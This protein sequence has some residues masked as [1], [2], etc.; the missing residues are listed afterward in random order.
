MPWHIR[1]GKVV[2]HLSTG[3]ECYLSCVPQAVRAHKAALQAQFHAMNW[4]VLGAHTD[5][6][7]S[8]GTLDFYYTTAFGA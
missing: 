6:R 8:P 4:A 5:R 3:C 7:F 1:M 2:V